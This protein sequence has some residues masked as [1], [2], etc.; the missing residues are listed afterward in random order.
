MAC[1]VQPETKGALP[2]FCR[3][4]NSHTHRH[5]CEFT[6]LDFEMAVHEHYSEVLDVIEQ[7]FFRI[8]EG[9]NQQCGECCDVTAISKSRIQALLQN[10]VDARFQ[11]LN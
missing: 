10:Q 9:I 11:D 8:F 1:F 7:L 4:E 5:L 6:G 2:P 3:A